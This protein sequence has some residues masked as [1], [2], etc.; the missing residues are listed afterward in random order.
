MGFTRPIFLF[1]FFPMAVMGVALCRWMERRIALLRRLRLADWALAGGS[2]LF[3]GWAVFDGIYR[4]FLYALAVWV[5]GR[6]IERLEA[7]HY[8]LPIFREEKDSAQVCHR[9]LWSLIALWAAVLLV[10]FWLFRFKYWSFIAPIWNAVFQTELTAASP[11]AP[12]GISFITFSAVSYL[13]DVR[14][15]LAPAGSFVDCLLYL[16]FFPKVISGPIVLWRDFQPQITVRRTTVEDA[17]TGVERIVIGLAKKVLL[18]DLLLGGIAEVNFAG[19]RAGLDLPSVF[20][21]MF[22]YMLVIYYDF[23][24]YSDIAIGLGRLFGFRFRENFNFPYRSRSITEFWR[25]WHISL[26][27]WFREY[28]YIPLGGSRKS[29]RRTLWNLAVVFALTG[30]WHGAGWNY[31]LWGGINGFF[32]ILERMIWDKEWYRRIPDGVKWVGT[33]LVVMLFWELFRFRSLSELFQWLALLRGGDVVFSWRYILDRRLMFLT[34]VGT[35]GA[36][37]LGGER[38]HSAWRR[39]AGTKLG[40]FLQEVGLLA[41]FVLAVMA[42]V[43]S[44]YSPFIYFQY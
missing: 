26:G 1:L 6:L 16:S 42:I 12:L 43:S 3:Y 5:A 20:L 32:V 7:G 9:V 10:L 40:L 4:L 13:V 28:V 19:G 38:A 8:V 11:L 15:G 33:M 36:T 22:L 44:D 41:L 2:L 21:G 31:I 17:A 23:A 27:T 18:A 39:A 30:V 37:V 14:R 24:G 34:V 25:R 29:R 35:L